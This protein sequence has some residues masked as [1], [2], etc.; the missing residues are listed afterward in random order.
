MTP[1]LTLRDLEKIQSD[2]DGLERQARDTQNLEKGIAGIRTGEKP[3]MDWYRDSSPYRQTEKSAID[4]VINEFGP[5]LMRI[6]EMRLAALAR[7]KKVAV[8][9][10]RAQLATI[11]AV[12]TAAQ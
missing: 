12:E 7:E 5:D 9:T 8:A 1:T 4:G 6:V 10:K 2:I 11:V 3:L